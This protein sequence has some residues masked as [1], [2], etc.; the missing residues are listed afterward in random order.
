MPF[1]DYILNNF[2]WKLLS[3]MLAA[4]TWL[5]I[6]TAFERD[7]TLQESPVVTSSTRSFPALPITLMTSSTNPNHYRV[8]PSTIA[9]DV[10]G[11]E[12]DLK[13]LQEKDV[14]LYVDISNVGDEKQVRRKIEAQ[15]P[16]DLK[17]TGLSLAYAN[18]ERISGPKTGQPSTNLNFP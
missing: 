6:R 17:I 8:E 2:W 1:R 10:S 3:L 7:Q 11:T 9:V 18:V 12:I 13:K 4:L 16:R 15:A 5:T 14:H